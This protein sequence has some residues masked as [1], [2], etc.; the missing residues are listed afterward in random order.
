MFYSDITPNLDG[1]YFNSINFVDD[2]FID[3]VNVV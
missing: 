2:F 1:H 3:K